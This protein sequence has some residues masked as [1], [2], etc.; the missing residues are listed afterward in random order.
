MKKIQNIFVMFALI[1]MYIRDNQSEKSQSWRDAILRMFLFSHITK[2][3]GRFL[4]RL[5]FAEYNDKGHIVISDFGR[6][7]I[8]NLF[9]FRP[10]K[11]GRNSQL[12]LNFR[13]IFSTAWCTNLAEA[14]ECISNNMAATN[15]A[16]CG[17][18]VALET[19]VTN[20]EGNLVFPQIHDK[21]GENRSLS[22][23]ERVAVSLIQVNAILFP[24]ASVATLIQMSR[25]AFYSKESRF[26]TFVTF[27]DVTRWDTLYDIAVGIPTTPQGEQASD[28]TQ[29]SEAPVVEKA[30]V[31]PV[32]V[33]KASTK[34]VA[35]PV[36]V[37]EPV[38]ATS[39]LD[40]E[41]FA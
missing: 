20:K 9:S 2:E 35:K 32:V 6:D 1:G 29:P 38:V 33:K 25:D 34:K 40:E 19:E 36:E 30:S 13:G 5:G 22:L 41:D 14:S 31:K 21:A 12:V 15:A 27:Q 39:F 24:K 4:V 8:N 26:S 28:S 17:T 16:L 7:T 23:A 11:D 18:I 37:E 3:T 10:G